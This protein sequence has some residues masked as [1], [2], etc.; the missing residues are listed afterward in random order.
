MAGVVLENLSNRKLSILGV[1]LLLVLV[2]FFLI[3]G[4]IAPSPSNVIS[5]LT[6]KCIDSKKVF[7]TSTWFNPRSTKSVQECD[8]VSSL[9]DQKLQERQIEANQIVFAQWLPLPRGGKQLDMSRWFQNVIAVIQIDIGYSEKNPIGPDPVLRMFASI[10]YRDKHDKEDDWKVLARAT[11]DRHLECH[12]DDHEKEEGVHYHCN[13]I[14]FFEL[15]SV[16]YDYYLVNIRIPVLESR[17]INLGIGSIEDIHVVVIHQNGGFTQV[18]FSMKTVVFPVLL[19]VLVW[20][21]NRIQKLS[22]LPNLLERTLFSLG[23]ILSI[24]NLPIEWLTLTFNM[25]YMLLVGDIRQ[26]AFYAMLLSFWMIFAGEHMMDQVERNK[27]SVYWK[28]LAAVIFGCVCLFVFEMCERGVQL[29]NPFFSI[30]TT[31]VGT[32]LALTFIILAG[33]SACLYFIFLC[34]MIFK[35]F[36]NI[37][38]KKLSLPHMS[39]VR[40]KFYMGL[41]YRF[42]FLMLITLLCAALTVIFFIISQVSEGSWKWGDENISLEYTS[43]FLTGV[44]G[45][46]NVYVIGL[47]CM[48]APSHKAVANDDSVNSSQEEEEVQLTQ[49]PSEASAL[50]SFAS[51]AATD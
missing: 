8:Q 43:A 48:Y 21:W 1:T 37:S 50:S 41:I 35:V 5:A 14:P 31:K 39:S 20:F 2:G 22:R 4:I 18:W 24:M 34:Y 32:N 36:R 49:I 16:H 27:L 11:E 40:R 45:M 30:W 28:H 47:L 7:N 42:K 13:L 19:A 17:G 44:Y 9:K 33:M 46:W 51:K 15:G 23:I 3:G 29:T 6:V 12:L 26:G 25:P 10:G 38:A